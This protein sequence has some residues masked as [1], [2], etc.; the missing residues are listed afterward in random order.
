M[1]I[2]TI[3]DNVLKPITT[4]KRYLKLIKL[5]VFTQQNLNRRRY[6]FVSV[7]L[8]SVYLILSFYKLWRIDVPCLL[9]K[10]CSINIIVQHFSS[11]STRIVLFTPTVV[12]QNALFPRSRIK[13]SSIVVDEKIYLTNCKTRSNSRFC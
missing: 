10:Y 13:I 11:L 5:I 8:F 12:S 9:E 6:A 1:F 3:P 4:T 2:A 7:I